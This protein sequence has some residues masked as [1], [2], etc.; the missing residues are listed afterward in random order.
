MTVSSRA[1]VS[2]G[3]DTLYLLYKRFSFCG[4]GIIVTRT[5]LSADSLHLSPSPQYRKVKLVKLSKIGPAVFSAGSPIHSGF[6]E[7]CLSALV[8]T[9]TLIILIDKLIN[10]ILDHVSELQISRL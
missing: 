6:R 10:F 5:L 8:S 3:A 4:P 2:G 1:G 7:A 9:L